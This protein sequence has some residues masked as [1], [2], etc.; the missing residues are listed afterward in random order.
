MDEMQSMPDL[1][2]CLK[3]QTVRD[4]TL[5][6]CVNQPDSWWDDGD[7]EHLRIC[8]A[9][10]ELLEFLAR[11]CPEAVLIN[12]SSRAR[13]WQGKTNGVGWARKVLFSRILNDCSGDE[14]IVSLDADT[15]FPDTYFE[16]LIDQFNRHPQCSA[17]SVPYF[18][19][20]SGDEAAD[21]LMLRYECYMRH[22]LINLFD[23]D[24][25]HA[26]SA[27]GSA[28]AFP[29]WAYRRVG[30][31]T[32]LQGGEDFYLMQKFAKTGLILC[33]LASVVNPS[34]RVSGRVPFGTGPAVGMA[35]GEQRQRYPFY[36]AAS[37]TL[38]E[39]TFA[40]FPTLYDSDAE[41]PMSPFL[42]QQLKTDDLWSPLRNNFKTRELFVRACAEKVDGLRILQYLRSVSSQ[43]PPEEP[44]VDFGTASI[45]TLDSYRN[46]LFMKEMRLRRDKKFVGI[47]SQ[48][49]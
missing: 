34:G 29:A 19:P 25:P 31:I 4:F 1:I 35:L 11:E 2:A 6:V 42:R 7:D 44:A 48:S 15:T 36:S 49:K 47:A 41:T 27:L 10:A 18:H 43:L 16:E 12:Y 8:R 33:S 20:L 5:Y 17:V 38:V 23:I 46:S 13:G 22:Y 3:R 30:G 28:M 24:N 14:I 26:F 39:R 32:P 21:R 37:F 40:M 45:A 9:N